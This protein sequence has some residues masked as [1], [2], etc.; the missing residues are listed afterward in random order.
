ML[1]HSKIIGDYKLMDNEVL[2]QPFNGTFTEINVLETYTGKE[3]LKEIKVI[4]VDKE[5]GKEEENCLVK[6]MV[7]NMA[8]FFCCWRKW[9]DKNG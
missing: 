4:V 9:T 6:L 1:I 7:Y 3:K 2:I 8:T 5:T